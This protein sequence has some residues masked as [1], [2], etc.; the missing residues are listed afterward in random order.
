METTFR[1]WL[2]AQALDR[3]TVAT[4]LSQANRLERHFGELGAAFDAD[5]FERIRSTLEYSKEDERTGRTNPAPFPIDGDLYSNLASYR[6]TLNYYAAFRANTSGEPGGIADPKSAARNGGASIIDRDEAR[7][8]DEGAEPRRPGTLKDLDR[9]ALSESAPS[10]SP[11]PPNFEERRYEASEGGYWDEE[12][13]YKQ[14]LIDAAAKIVDRPNRRPDQIGDELMGLLGSKGSNLL[15][16]RELRRIEEVRK[17]APGL[18]ERALGNLVV[19]RMAETAAVG[20]FVEE[21][22]DAYCKGQERQH[23]IR[24]S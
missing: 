1:D 7:P 22:A 15:D 11:A 14:A 18:I 8:E 12:R 4:Q 3:K 2:T 23:A 17:E 6:T 19:S 10:S 9:A 24:A 21:L 20:R 13:R 5:H 16:W